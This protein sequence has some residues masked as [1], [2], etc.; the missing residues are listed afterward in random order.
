MA[1][2]SY[3]RKKHFKSSTL[4]SGEGSLFMNKGVSNRDYEESILKKSLS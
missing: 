4:R 1:N 2:C 3:V